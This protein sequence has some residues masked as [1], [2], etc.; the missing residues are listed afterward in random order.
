MTRFICG[1]RGDRLGECPRLPCFFGIF[2][3]DVRRTSSPGRFYG[4]AL[5][6]TILA[7][8]IQN[9]DFHLADPDAPRWFTW[10]TCRVPKEGTMVVFTPREGR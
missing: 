7:H 6:K 2:D 5:V 9:Y 8:L 10:R 4:T 1:V 3:A